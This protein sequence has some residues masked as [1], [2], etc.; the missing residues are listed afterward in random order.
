[1][2]KSVQVDTTP[3]QMAGEK[4]GLALVAFSVVLLDH[5]TKFLVTSQVSPGSAIPVLGDCLR[6]VYVR[7]S[8]AAFGLFRDSGTPLVFISIAA[9]ILVL[10]Y[11]FIVPRERVLGRRALALILGGALGNMLDRIFRSGEVVDFIDMGIGQRFRWPAYNVADIAVTVGVA[12]LVV[13]FIWDAGRRAD[14]ASE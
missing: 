1:M 8:G 2:T 5:V 10:L 4:C 3:Q 13:E 14:T 7:N 9:S 6:L 12:L 11:L